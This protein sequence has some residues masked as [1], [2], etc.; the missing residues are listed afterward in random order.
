MLTQH[1]QQQQQRDRLRDRQT[2]GAMADS[3]A[4]SEIDQ[5]SIAIDSRD[6]ELKLGLGLRT[7]RCSAA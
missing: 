3:R 1:Q 4:T 6:F 7:V 2:Q 5:S